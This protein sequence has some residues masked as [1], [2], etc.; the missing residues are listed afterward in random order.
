MEIP[1]ER[2]GVTM[3]FKQKELTRGDNKGS[4]VMAPPDI[5]ADNVMQY[6]PFYGLKELVGILAGRT[7]TLAT[8]WT[9]SAE[10]G[11]TGEFL[12]DAFRTYV[13]E[14]SA[15]GE[16]MEELNDQISDKLDEMNVAAEQGDSARIVE[17]AKEIKSLKAE[18]ESKKRPRKEKK[19][20]VAT[21]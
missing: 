4:L 9:R 21:A 17:L 15:R 7:K 5:T 6:I 1:V 14:W 8:G 20:E 10:D 2:N 3:M 11:E 19:A 16:S 12:P 13:Q 18:I